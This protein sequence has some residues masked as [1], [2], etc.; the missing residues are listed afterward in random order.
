M[1]DILKQ[2]IGDQGEL[3]PYQQQALKLVGELRRS[4]EDDQFLAFVGRATSLTA[5][6]GSIGA[7][8]YQLI[9]E[10]NFM[11]LKYPNPFAL[12]I[13][14]PVLAIWG[15]GKWIEAHHKS[16]I[17]DATSQANALMANLMMDVLKE[18]EGKSENG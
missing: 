8:L 17:N 7:V 12:E 13:M 10:P 3:R 16:K 15:A 18:R 11:P 2:T 1:T 5:E 14:L 9:R 4:T 6:L